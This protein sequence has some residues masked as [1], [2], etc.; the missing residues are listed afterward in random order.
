VAGFIVRKKL[1]FTSAPWLPPDCGLPMPAP[2]PTPLHAYQNT[3][4]PRLA[5]FCELGLQASLGA[6]GKSLLDV[7]IL[8]LT[9][10][11]RGVGG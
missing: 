9:K 11:R 1:A 7:R 2:S 6:D 3:S 5:E 8:E 4:E 10:Q